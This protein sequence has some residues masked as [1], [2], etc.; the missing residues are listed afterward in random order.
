[1]AA[2]DCCGADSTGPHHAWCRNSPG[3][4]APV[5]V[6]CAAEQTLA[7]VRA[8]V[9][10]WGSPLGLPG[11]RELLAALGGHQRGDGSVVWGPSEQEQERAEA[12]AQRV[13]QQDKE[14]RALRIE[15]GK[16]KEAGRG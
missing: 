8:I 14:L 3:K 9:S 7:R 15:N 12:L 10:R 1:M 6:G 2:F 5:P 13:A 11:S 16:L 4:A